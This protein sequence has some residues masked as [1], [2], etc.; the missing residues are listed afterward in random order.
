[1]AEDVGSGD[2]T[3][4]AVVPAT[5][6]TSVVFRTREECVVAGFPIVK[7]IFHEIDPACELDVLC[8]DGTFCP[9]N[10]DLAILRGPARAILTGERSALNFLQRL[11]GIATMTKRYVDALGSSTTKLLDTR[12]TTPCLRL[13]EKYAVA[14]GGGTNHR[15]GLFDRIMIKDNH[16]HLADMQGPGGIGRSVKACRD[17][18]P[19]LEVEVEADT[20]EHVREALDAK[21]DYILLDN[22]SNDEMREC[23]MLRDSF[24]PQSLLAHLHIKNLFHS[25]F[26]VILLKKYNI[27]FISLIWVTSHISQHL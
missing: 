10:S 18:Y 19:K 27:S 14:C 8:G 17:A 3:T 5:M 6:R 16:R 22:M 11:S 15:F 23:V 13:L 9:P 25:H 2:A 1:L 21:A 4:L 26:L 20:Q 24:N 12:K 7:A